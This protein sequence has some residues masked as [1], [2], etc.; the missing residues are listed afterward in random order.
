MEDTP[1]AHIESIFMDSG[2]HTLYNVHVLKSTGKQ[3]RPG[4]HGRDLEAANVVWGRGD[5]S[6]FDLSKGSPFRKYCDRYASFIKKFGKYVDFFATVDAISNPDLTWEIQRYFEE[7]HGVQPV[8][9]VHYG[10]PMEYVD[11]YLETG[12]YDF[13]GVGG[14]GQGVSRGQYY[15]WGDEFFTHICPASNNYLPVIKTHGFAMTSWD[16][17]TRWPWWSVDSATWVKVAAYGHII[18]PRWT[19]EGGFRFDRPPMTV[20]LSNKSPNQKEKDK[21][22]KNARPG[23]KGQVRA[24]LNEIGIAL[25]VED[26]N[27]EEVERGVLTHHQPRSLANIH[28]FQRLAASRPPWPH[29]LNKK[30]VACCTVN[31]QKGF[32]L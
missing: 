8:P 16:L 29:P 21:H 6:Y 4:K 1:P 5:F 28:Y 15:T 31:Y 26:E 27:G 11:R 2:A 30:I 17:I 32:G 10:T 20:T 13:L 25:G 23:V 9:I 19:P 7:E 3:K 12:R 18:V 14:L 24:W 22:Y